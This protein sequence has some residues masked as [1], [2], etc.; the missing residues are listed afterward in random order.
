M[1]RHE[2]RISNPQVQPGDCAL[3]L[4]PTGLGIVSRVLPPFGEMLPFAVGAFGR[5][6]KFA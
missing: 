6:S 1:G 2:T 3:I 4:M 5:N